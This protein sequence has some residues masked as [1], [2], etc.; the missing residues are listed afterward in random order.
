MEITVIAAIYLGPDWCLV[1]FFESNSVQCIL[2]SSILQM[3]QG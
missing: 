2:Y 1:L 3:N